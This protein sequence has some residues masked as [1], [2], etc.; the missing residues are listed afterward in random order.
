MVLANQKCI[1]NTKDA[2][3]EIKKDKKGRIIPKPPKPGWEF[4]DTM[5]PQSMLDHQ[6]IDGWIL[7]DVDGFLWAHRKGKK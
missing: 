5:V 7:E 1:L 4:V 3:K 6:E 2:P